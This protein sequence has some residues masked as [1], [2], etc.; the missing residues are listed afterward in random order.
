MSADDPHAAPQPPDEPRARADRARRD[1]TAGE[2]PLDRLE[3]NVRSG[4]MAYWYTGA[5]IV[6]TILS[7]IVVA[8]AGAVSGG[9]LCDAG[10]SSFICSRTWEIVFP[11]VPSAV[12]L[13]GALGGFWQCYSK[14]RRFE[15]WRPWIAMVWILLPWTLIWM[16]STMPILMLGVAP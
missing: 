8:V 12:S 16:T 1:R 15:R 11:L 2:D 13:V 9:P 3:R 5:V 7:A 14:W 4:R 10:H 6:L